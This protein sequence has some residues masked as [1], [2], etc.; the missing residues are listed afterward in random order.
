MCVEDKAEGCTCL[1]QRMCV[2]DEGTWIRRRE[3]EDVC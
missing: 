1:V 2:E 3:A